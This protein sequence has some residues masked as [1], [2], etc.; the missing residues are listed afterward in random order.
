[1]NVY[2]VT[3]WDCIQ[4]CFASEEDAKEYISWHNL[5]AGIYNLIIHEKIFHECFTNEMFEQ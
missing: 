4:E 3:N 2:V 1:M 5:Y